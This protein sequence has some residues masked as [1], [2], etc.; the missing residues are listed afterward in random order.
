MS[1]QILAGVKIQGQTS[2]SVAIGTVTVNF[3]SD[4]TWDFLDASSDRIVYNG[5]CPPI[6]AL[7]QLLFVGSGGLA[8]G[9]K[10]F[11]FA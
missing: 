10:L 7:L 11:G 2:G 4:G 8:T 9:T 3:N 6:N 1:T 5:D